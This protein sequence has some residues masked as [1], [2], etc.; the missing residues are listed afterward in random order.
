MLTEL[1]SR[2]SDVLGAALPAPFAG[3][4]RRRGAPAPAGPGPVVRLGVQGWTPL[5]PDVFSTRPELGAG[6]PTLRRVVRLRVVIGVDVASDPPGDRL[7]ELAGTDALVYALQ[8]PGVRTAS[9]L[10][11]P[12]D[13]GFRLD[14]LELAPVGE[15]DDDPDVLVHAEGWFWP[16]GVAG[17]DGR[18]IAHALVREVRLP[19]RLLLGGALEAGGAAVACDLVFGSTGTLDVTPGSTVAAP[20]G[21]VALRVLDAGGGPGAG[22][23]GAVGSPPGSTVVATVD[24]AG[25]AFTYTPPAVAAR[26]HLVVLAHARNGADERIGMELARFDLTVTP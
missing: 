21:A 22:V 19:V 13:Q 4:V 7:G 6:A 24:G 14:S 1:E 8:D 2:L 16:V 12:G 10:V 26:E 25:T 11:A 17:Q 9:A 18:E 15:S 5:E 20:F 23:L 3:R